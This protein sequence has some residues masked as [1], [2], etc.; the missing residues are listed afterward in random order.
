MLNKPPEV[1]EGSGNPGSMQPSSYLG[2]V[3]EPS[4]VAEI[5]RKP[6]GCPGN[7]HD[8]AEVVEAAGHQGRY[9]RV[10]HEY[11]LRV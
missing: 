11:Y 6:G 1:L 9:P 8:P 5:D 2:V 3:H 10:V 4:V 7:V